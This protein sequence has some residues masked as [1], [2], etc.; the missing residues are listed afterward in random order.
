MT[1]SLLGVAIALL[2]FLVSTSPSLLP[3]PWWAQ[4]AMSGA[5]MVGGY[6][7]GFVIDWL[8][9]LVAEIISLR[10]SYDLGASWALRALLLTALGG[11]FIVG[12][13]VNYRHMRQTARNVNMPPPSGLAYLGSLVGAFVIVAAIV[14]LYLLIYRLWKLIV[15]LFGNHIPG[16][17]AAVLAWA[18]VFIIVVV[19]VEW[20]VIK[21]IARRAS[22]WASTRDRQIP[23]G[24]RAPL[25]PERSASPQSV[26]TWEQTSRE[27]KRFLGGEPMT[28]RIEQV[29]GRF[30]TEPIRVYASLA[31]NGDSLSRAVHQ[32]VQELYRTGAFDR[33]VLLVVVPTGSGWVDEWNVQALEYLTGGDCASVA[34]QYS[35]LPSWMTFVSGREQAGRGGRVIVDAVARE[36]A[37]LDPDR[38]PRLFV[39]GESLGSFGAQSAFHSPADMLARVDGALWI[40]TP[41]FT[42]VLRELTR[43]RH[44]GSPQIAPVV[45]NARHVR[46]ATKPEDLTRD[47]DGRELG[48]WEFPRVVYAQHASDPVVWWDKDLMWKTPDW[49]VEGVGSDVSNH[50]RWYR[51][52]TYVQLLCDLPLAESAS[53]GHGH[54]YQDELVP[55]W[56][57]I[58]GLKGDPAEDARI[59]TAISQHLT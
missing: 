26:V 36:I 16:W 39:T 44:R 28:E 37:K 8:A 41:G 46:F 1:F 7:L 54:K 40:G 49:M 57:A 31:A 35:F 14:G 43:T 22:R 18:I 32:A 52:V 29:T 30:A 5:L 27:G 20:G 3:R 21:Q 12:L 17:A 59:V 13:T 2:L 15:G 23:E 48:A 25:I 4:A 51:L 45:D 6:L 9:R 10:V 53:P 42:E 33:S 56:R 34:V 11:L 50:L 58:L 55:A 38:R 47:I 24:V 19:L